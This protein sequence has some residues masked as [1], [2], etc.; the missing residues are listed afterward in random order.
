MNKINLMDIMESLN[1]DNHDD[2]Q[3]A[4]HE[5]FVE[6]GRQ[7]H[8][9]MT[10]QQVSEE[11]VDEQVVV[12]NS[13][14]DVFDILDAVCDQ[15]LATGETEGSEQFD[16]GDDL[17]N[18]YWIQVPYELDNFT[19][20]PKYLA[21]LESKVEDMVPVDSGYYPDDEKQIGI[22]Y[23]AAIWGDEVEESDNSSNQVFESK[24]EDEDNDDD[25]EEVS[26]SIDDIIAEL[27]EGFSGLETVSDKLQNQE[28]AQVGEQ[29]KVPVN[30]KSPLPNHKGAD[31][32]AGAPVE[33][34][35]DE[36]K[37]YEREKAPAV[38]D[39]MTS[40]HVQ[41]SKEELKDVKD[42]G[43]KSALLNKIEGS[44]NTQSPISG[45]GGTGLKK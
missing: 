44:I 16:Y 43:D 18:L 24:D 38:K 39:N 45:K 33:V 7:V 1:S 12:E 5:W 14:D 40:R 23:L 32:L 37:G 34:H 30:T 29:G 42:G 2:A 17:A 8:S 22:V 15:I 36:H 26:E 11:P 31:R 27:R 41:N 35:S 10:G 4:L 21:S 3:A 6:Q 25:K 13:E 20:D 9:K 19:I 28:G